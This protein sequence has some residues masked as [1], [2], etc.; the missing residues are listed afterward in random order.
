MRDGVRQPCAGRPAC[1]ECRKP[2][3]T[4]SPAPAAG[5]GGVTG[6]AGG[7][8]GRGGR[9]EMAANTGPANPIHLTARECTK[10]VAAG[11]PGRNKAGGRWLH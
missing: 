7:A 6:F 3:T 4:G 2:P 8:T 5:G 9:G 10:Q 11:L 1:G